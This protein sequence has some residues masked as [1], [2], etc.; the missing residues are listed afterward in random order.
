VVDRAKMDWQHIPWLG[1]EGLLVLTAV[2]EGTQ[3]L[4]CRLAGTASSCTFF[5]APPVPPARV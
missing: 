4:N 3:L 1:V 2:K 5:T